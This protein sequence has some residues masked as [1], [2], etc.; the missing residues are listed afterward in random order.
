MSGDTK[1]P[2]LT[3]HLEKAH[4]DLSQLLAVDD[5]ENQGL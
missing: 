1:Y 3:I 4:R 5:C 2:I